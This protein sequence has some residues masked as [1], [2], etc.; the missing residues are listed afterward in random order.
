MK[1]THPCVE[2]DTEECTHM[3]PGDNLQNGVT[4]TQRR[5]YGA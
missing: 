2:D 1:K 3:H 5:R 4:L